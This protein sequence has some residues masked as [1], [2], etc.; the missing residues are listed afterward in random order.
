MLVFLNV[1]NPLQFGN[2]FYRTKIEL[3][4]VEVSNRVKDLLLR[5]SIKS[6]DKS[7]SII[8]PDADNLVTMKKNILTEVIAIDKQLR[9]MFVTL[10]AMWKMLRDAR[11]AR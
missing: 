2:I 11:I 6:V 1:E 5:K 7:G 8:A 9:D 3:S 10:H 4:T